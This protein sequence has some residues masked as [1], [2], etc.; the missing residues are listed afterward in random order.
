[1][2]ISSKTPKSSL[3]S[4]V[5]PTYNRRNL[6]QPCLQSV[7]N[8]NHQQL[9]IVVIDNGS[10]DDTIEQVKAINDPRIKLFLE[11][12]RGAAAARN[13][14]VK[15]ATGEFLTFLDSDDLWLTHK[16]ADQINHLRR[17]NETSMVFSEYREFNNNNVDELRPVKESSMMLSVITMMV[18]REAFLRVGYFDQTLQAGEFMHWYARALALGLK[19]RAIHDV[20]ALRRLHDSNSSSQYQSKASYAAACRSILEMRRNKQ[21]PDS[22]AALNNA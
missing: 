5:I 16:T 12:L 21:S 22:A 14:G 17:D 10:S 2:H 20:V 1:M 6:I 15:H 19:S 9:E 8:Q 18:R 3:V 11:P 7:L 13:T 4:V